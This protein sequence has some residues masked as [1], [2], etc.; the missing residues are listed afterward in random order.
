MI[1]DMF[2]NIFTKIFTITQ[3]QTVFS[4]NKKEGQFLKRFCAVK[5][6]GRKLP[7]AILLGG[8]R[9]F[10]SGKIS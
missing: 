6:T 3:H 7:G 2:T 10:H 5:L 8:G 1:E 9:I 4:A